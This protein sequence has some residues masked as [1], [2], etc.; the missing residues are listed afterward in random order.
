MYS[1]ND[2]SAAR[3]AIDVNATL[4][5]FTVVHRRLDLIPPPGPAGRHRLASRRQPPRSLAQAGLGLIASVF[6]CM[7]CLAPAAVPGARAGSVSPTDPESVLRTLVKANE[8]KDLSTMSRLMAHDSDQVNYS[9]G[10]RKFVGWDAFADEM[11]LEFEAV[12]RLEIPIRDLQVWVR[13]N[14][15]W[16]AMELDYIRYFG[17]GAA[18]Q[19]TLLPLRETGV[20]ERRAGDW[21]VVAWHESFREGGPSYAGNDGS[22]GGHPPEAVVTAVPS[23]TLD[24]SGKWEIQEEDKSYVA[25]LDRE[26]NGSYTWQNGRIVTIQVTGGLWQGTWHQAGNDREGAFEVRLSEDGSEARGVWWYTR[27]GDRNNI[28]PRQWGGTYLWK[29]LESKPRP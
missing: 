10:G 7:A 9:I 22:G 14:V 5:P 26:G 19:N 27:V 25:T 3:R 16:F 13:G 4:T 11:R 29:R 21:V 23:P 15:A 12:S 17:D 8:R 28:P 24:L 2:T 20:L 1:L 6:T 18:Q